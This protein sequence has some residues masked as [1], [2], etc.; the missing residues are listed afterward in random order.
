M[1]ESRSVVVVT[2][3]ETF[4]G[5]WEEALAPAGLGVRAA[6][7]TEAPGLLARSGAALVDAGCE[8]FE[9]DEDELLTLVGLARALG[10]PVAVH[11]REG[12]G[13][14]SSVVPLLEELCGGLLVRDE[15]EAGRVAEALA[16]RLE[17]WRA[18]RFEF[19]TVSPSE[20]DHLLA[21]MGDG[22]AV[23]MSRPLT[24][25]DDGTAV[26]GIDISEDA[27]E[28]EV[29]LA[30]GRRVRLRALT[31]AA[32]ARD[33]FGVGGALDGHRLGRRLRELRMA[34]GLT[35]AE[36]ARRTGIHRPNIARVEA[37]RHTPSLDTLARIAHAIGV[38]TTQVLGDGES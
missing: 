8:A 36:L 35:Q 23:L 1:Q 16:R 5:T 18:H 14:S 34:A 17:P 37:G 19:L 27:R 2:E 20:E 15:T 21:V 4:L 25:D 26:V 6:S 33:G 22:R 10:A 12:N 24:M 13:A 9:E 30:S 38:P 3:R 29:E 32:A 31:A 7:P 28:A 11:L